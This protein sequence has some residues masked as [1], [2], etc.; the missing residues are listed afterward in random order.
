MTRQYALKCTDRMRCFTNYQ[1]FLVILEHAQTVW[2]RPSPQQGEWP[3]GEAMAHKNWQI[4]EV[5]MVQVT[6]SMPTTGCIPFTLG[7][8]LINPR[9]TPS[10]LLTH[11]LVYMVYTPGRHGITITYS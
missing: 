10:G 4:P 11:Y 2:T 7:N 3:G 9:A 5:T 6:Y 8:V 1:V